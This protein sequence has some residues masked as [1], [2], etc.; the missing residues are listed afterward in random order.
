MNFSQ[1]TQKIRE[2]AKEIIARAIL[3]GQNQIHDLRSGKA[4]AVEIE[5]RMFLACEYHAEKMQSVLEELVR[6][7][8]A[9][10]EEQVVPRANEEPFIGHECGKCL[11]NIYC[12]QWN[13]CRAQIINSFKEIQGL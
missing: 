9:W 11:R 6:E 5:S 13:L 1:H 7:T 3:D 12:E 10:A 4:T 2:K 8:L